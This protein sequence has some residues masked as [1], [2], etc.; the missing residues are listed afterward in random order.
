MQARAYLTINTAMIQNASIFQKVVDEVENGVD[1]SNNEAGGLSTKGGDGGSTNGSTTTSLEE[2]K[3]ERNN[4]GTSG[5]NDAIRSKLH[6]PNPSAFGKS[7]S[8]LGT[9]HITELLDLE[10]NDVNLTL[11]TKKREKMFGKRVEKKKVILNNISGKI[12]SACLTGILGPSGSG[13]TSLLNLLAA[14]LLHDKKLELTGTLLSN[15]KPITNWSK[16]RRTCSYVEQDDLLFHNLTVAE[17]LYFYAELR[18]PR[19]F[20][21]EE[22]AERVDAVIN[23]LSLKKCK[24][25]K[26]GNARVRG[27]SGG[28]RKRVSIAVEILRGPVMV[29]LDEPTS[30]LDSTKSLQV[31]ETMKQMAELGRTVVASVHQPRSAIWQM[32]DNVIILSEGRVMYQGEAKKLVVGSCRASVP[33]C[34]CVCVCVMRRLT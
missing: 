26:I 1:S 31:V 13:K 33:P 16:H 18:L 30:G 22:R 10:F 23:E 34:V 4:S 8:F 32:F 6:T 2:E 20:S 11:T 17:T 7:T 28:E 9:Q 27:I 25:T 24:D 29:L 15:G 14:R 21:K 12:Y 19:N 3:R 5:E